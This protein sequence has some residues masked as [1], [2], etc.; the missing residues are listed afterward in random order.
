M[1]QADSISKIVSG[2]TIC[3]DISLNIPPNSITVLIGPNGAGKTTFFQTIA[4]LQPPSRGKLWLHNQDIT[5]LAF[6]QRARLGLGYLPQQ[7]SLFDGMTVAENIATGLEQAKL[8]Y[9][10]KQQRLSRLI[11]EFQLEHIINNPSETISGGEK[12]RTELARALSQNPSYLLLDEPFAGVDPISV[13]SMQTMLKKLKKQNN[14]GIFISDHNV[15]ETMAIAD[16]VIVMSKGSIIAQG[17]PQ[18][19]LNNPAV[20]AHYLG[21]DF[22]HC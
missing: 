13:T 2:K 11:G 18:S 19:I 7:P 15:R 12:R 14:L 16:H 17:S 21:H 6:Y 5:S 22:S 4:G 3:K 9:S 20:K 1:L 10:E 8:S